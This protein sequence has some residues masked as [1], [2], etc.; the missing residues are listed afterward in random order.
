M[1]SIHSGNVIASSTELTFEN[2]KQH[3]ILDHK[4]E[5]IENLKQEIVYLKEM[6]AS[7]KEIMN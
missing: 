4:D 2:Q 6:L 5:A 7:H 3:L 1:N